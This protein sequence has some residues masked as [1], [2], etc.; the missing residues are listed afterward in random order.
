MAQLN[1]ILVGRFNRGLQKLF[2]I[3]GQAPVATL[4]P[5]IM[6]TLTLLNG[7]E[8]RYLEGWNR[9]GLYLTI[10]AGAATGSLLRIRNPITSN[11]IAIIEKMTVANNTAAAAQYNIRH[12]NAN[13]ADAATLN[14]PSPTQRWDSRGNPSTAL[15]VSSNSGSAT[16]PTS[17]GIT[18]AITCLAVNVAW[19]FINCEDQE[20]TLLPGD[21][22]D[23]FMNTQAVALDVA[24]FWRERQLEESERA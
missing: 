19:E 15:S 18:K 21:C 2:G 24:W 12:G 3:K 22:L 6:P 17:P 5:E 9:L 14:T 20:M 10:T 7:V 16:T 11:V 8:N 4:A 1:E 13:N 23:V